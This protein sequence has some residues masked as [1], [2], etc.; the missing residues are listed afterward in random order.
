MADGREPV[1]LAMVLCDAIHIDPGTGKRT[2]LGLFSALFTNQFPTVLRQMA[3]YAALTE[4][5]GTIPFTVEVVDANLEREPVFRTEGEIPT[6]DPLGVIELNMVMGNLVFPEQGEYRVRLLSKGFP[7]IERR[8][9]VA[10]PPQP[11]TPSP[12]AEEP[13]NEPPAE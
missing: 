9:V 1:A 7:L 3:V 6:T 5:H 13:T 10:R 12:P 2:L 4:C 8:L 11:P